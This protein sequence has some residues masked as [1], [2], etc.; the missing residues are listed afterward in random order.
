MQAARPLAEA[1]AGNSALRTPE[2]PSP[3]REAFFTALRQHPFQQVRVKYL[4]PVAYRTPK[5]PKAV[6]AVGAF[7]KEKLWKKH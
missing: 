6:D 7:L 3:E 2:E 1:V 4:S 5:T